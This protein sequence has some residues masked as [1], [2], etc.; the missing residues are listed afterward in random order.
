MPQPYLLLPALMQRISTIVGTQR[1]LLSRDVVEQLAD[2]DPERVRPAIEA[3]LKDGYLAEDAQGR[4]R[5]VR[6]FRG[7]RDAGVETPNDP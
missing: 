6:P 5:S 2:A 3:L 1:K 7:P 4:L